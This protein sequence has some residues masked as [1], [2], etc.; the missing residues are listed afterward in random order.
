MGTRH[1]YFNASKMFRTVC[2]NFL[3]TLAIHDSLSAVITVDS[4]DILAQATCSGTQ[5]ANGQGGWM[6]AVRRDCAYQPTL[7]CTDICQDGTLR[8]QD[9]QMVADNAKG[10]CQSAVY[11]YPR[12]YPTTFNQLGLKIVPEPCDGFKCGANYCCCHFY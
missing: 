6:Y 1:G 4:M 12:S 11:V 3:I 2:I 5:Q 10:H 9:P 8:I 7:T